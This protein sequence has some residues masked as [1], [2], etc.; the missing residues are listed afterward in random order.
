MPEQEQNLNP[1][2]QDFL[3]D[4]P[5][6]SNYTSNGGESLEAT[7]PTNP[8]QN[9]SAKRS[10]V[11]LAVLFVA[12]IVSVYG[13][14]MYHG[15]A[16]AQ[17][18]ASQ[19]A[20]ELQVD[21]ALKRFAPSSKAGQA[22]AQKAKELLSD[23]YEQALSKQIP[24]AALKDNPFE[25]KPPVLPASNSEQ[26]GQET[27]KTL[28]Q[29]QLVL[30]RAQNMQLQSVILAGERSAAVISGNLV[31]QGQKYQE[32]TVSEIHRKQVVLQWKNKTFR[33]KMQE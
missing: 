30:A 24:L 21:N 16:K 1:L 3:S 14:K 25:F 6:D 2:G 20:M 8:N 7:A 33:L 32:W 11:I 4:A 17:A 12:G 18:S 5:A 28:N 19:Q 22:P 10:N 26:E 27:P 15:P 31:M 23:V 29:G 9:N 13:L